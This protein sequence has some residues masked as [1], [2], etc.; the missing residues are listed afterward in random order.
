MVSGV[1]C[2]FEASLRLGQTRYKK[3]AMSI[4]V[5]TELHGSIICSQSL[6]GD[7]VDVTCTFRR[8]FA[9]IPMVSGAPASDSAGSN[10]PIISKRR[11]HFD[12]GG[13]AAMPTPRNNAPLDKP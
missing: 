8:F 9:I 13:V 1:A 11:R 12:T 5:A 2:A 3:R 6:Q 10:R 7:A 4:L